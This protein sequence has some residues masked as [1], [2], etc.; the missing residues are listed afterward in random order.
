MLFPAGV[1]VTIEVRSS[2]PGGLIRMMGRK[3]KNPE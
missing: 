1:P 3:N 2:K